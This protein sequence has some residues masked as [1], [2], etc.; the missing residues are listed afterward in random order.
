MVAAGTVK[1]CY[2]RAVVGEFEQFGKQ[3]DHVRERLGRVVS[4]GTVLLLEQAHERS[5]ER[6][7]ILFFVAR[8]L[9]FVG[10]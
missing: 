1:T 10:R 8:P 2:W 9:Q 7:N 6:M 3:L 5:A 4:T